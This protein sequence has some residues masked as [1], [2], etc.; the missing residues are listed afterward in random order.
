MPVLLRGASQ[1]RL[2][3]EN[4]LFSRSSPRNEARIRVP[5]LFRGASQAR[6]ARENILFSR[7]SP[8][9]EES[10]KYCTEFTG[11]SFP[12]ASEQRVGHLRWESAVHRRRPGDQRI[13][14][15]PKGAAGSS[16][17]LSARRLSR[18]WS[19]DGE[20]RKPALHSHSGGKWSNR[21]H[22]GVRMRWALQSKTRLRETW[23]ESQSPGTRL[24]LMFVARTIV[25]FAVSLFGQ[26]AL[27]VAV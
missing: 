5:V 11:A 3:R 22:T 23:G 7:S 13:A 15:S 6:L 18:L 4:I 21:V 19:G 17:I 12:A 16:G 10:V 24:A 9:H 20:Q 25:G 2:A 8:L 14:P 27:Q 1:A 26:F